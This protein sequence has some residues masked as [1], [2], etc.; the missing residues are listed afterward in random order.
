[1]TLILGIDVAGRGPLIGPMILAG[2]LVTQ[3]QDKILRSKGAVDSKSITHKVRMLVAKEIESNSLGY[4]VQLS[5]PEEIDKSILSGVN[6]NTLEAMKAA[7]IIN[8]LNNKKDKIKVIVDCPSVNTKSWRSKLLE[9]IDNK[10][11]LDVHCEHK[12]DVNHPS[13]SAAS[14]LAKVRREEEVELIKKKYDEYGNILTISK[15]DPDKLPSRT[16]ATMGV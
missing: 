14:I 9:F 15:F 6:L 13:V 16:Y 2:V 11:N 8:A 5:S 1:M 7:N 12:A 10:D 3:E 4:N